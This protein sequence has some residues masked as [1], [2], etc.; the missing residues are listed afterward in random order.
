MSY[1][2]QKIWH[3]KHKQWSKKLNGLDLNE[4]EASSSRGAATTTYWW[5]K[6]ESKGLGIPLG[7][8]SESKGPTIPLAP[9]ARSVR[10]SLDLSAQ[11]G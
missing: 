8:S 2:I 7:G 4:N 11:G 6:Q 10:A 9:A 5:L 3:Q 1:H